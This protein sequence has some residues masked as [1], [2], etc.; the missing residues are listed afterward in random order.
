MDFGPY[1]A[2]AICKIGN[3]SNF[4]V[5]AC[6]KYL[7]FTSYYVTLFVV[8]LN[9]LVILVLAKHLW[10][11]FWIVDCKGKGGKGKQKCNEKSVAI[12]MMN[13]EQELSLQCVDDNFCIEVILAAFD[14]FR[15]SETKQD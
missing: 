12:N 3:S 5:V 10:R 9:T 4:L 1:W 8:F 2:S 13:E 7:D 11:A 6:R 15:V 14:F